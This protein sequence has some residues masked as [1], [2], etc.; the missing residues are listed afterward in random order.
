MR[1]QLLPRLPAPQLG[2]GRRLVPLPRVPAAFA[3]RRA[4]AQ[5]GPG[6]ADGE[7]AAPAP[8]LRAPRPVRPPPGSAAALLRGGPAA[9]VLGVQ[10]VPGAPGAHPGAHRRGL[11]QLPGE[12][13]VAGLPLLPGTCPVYLILMKVPSK[14][15]KRHTDL[16]A[17]L[18]TGMGRVCIEF[19]WYWPWE[20]LV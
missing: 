15:V 19:S 2:A 7:D 5:L 6:P 3:A 8:G 14:E 1:P 17:G 10:G 18:K 4:A 13:A 12:R 20:L 11:L 9:R 16:R